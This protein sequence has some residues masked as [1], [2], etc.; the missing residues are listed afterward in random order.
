MDPDRPALAPA[1]KSI[2][3]DSSADGGVLWLGEA[4]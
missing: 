1:Y 4:G 2:I 3:A